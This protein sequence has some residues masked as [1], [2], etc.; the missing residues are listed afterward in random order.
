MR[1]QRIGAP[2]ECGRVD[3]EPDRDKFPAKT[4]VSGCETRAMD[5]EVE[6]RA[7]L[8]PADA[9]ASENLAGLWR[10]RNSWGLATALAPGWPEFHAPAIRSDERHA[11]HVRGATVRAGRRPRRRGRCRRRH[12]FLLPST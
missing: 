9:G 8:R 4:D 10:N 3:R 6:W 1:R 5:P 12:L 11:P 7:K 2:R